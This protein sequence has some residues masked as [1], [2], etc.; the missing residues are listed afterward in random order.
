MACKYKLTYFSARGLGEPIR[1]MLSYG[2]QQF[3]DIRLTIEEFPKVKK[4]MPFGKVPILEEDGKLAHQ[5]IAI[6][7]YLAKKFGIAG[8][9][10]WEALQIDSVTD[11]IVDLR[12]AIVNYAFYTEESEKE[13][14]REKLMNETIPV[15]L[16]RLDKIAEENKG[17]FVNG[18]LTYADIV[19]GAIV[20]FLSECMKTNLLEGY[21]H[22]QTVEHKVT[23]LANIQS[24]IN[25]RPSTEY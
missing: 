15:Y 11:T 10:D 4:S 1:Y 3:Q 7:R 2:G 18:K 17:Y 23:T 9:D 5:S 24:W 25:R 14:E 16:T 12:I 8:S 6:C 20:D 22:L 19:F 13:K 21:E